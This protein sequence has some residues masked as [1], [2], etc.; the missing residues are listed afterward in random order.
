MVILIIIAMPSLSSS[1][2]CYVVKWIVI[3]EGYG[4]RNL[5]T[6]DLHFGARFSVDFL[7]RC[8]RF[9]ACYVCCL[10]APNRRTSRAVVRVG[11][12]LPD[13]SN[14]GTWF[15]QRVSLLRFILVGPWSAADRTSFLRQTIHF[16]GVNSFKKILFQFG[17]CCCL[18]CKVH[19]RVNV[20]VSCS[21][22]YLS[23]V[24]LCR[25][26][27]FHWSFSWKNRNLITF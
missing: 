21:V 18:G 10:R 2:A 4:S 8:V 16:E 27:L 13:F 15:P 24:V 25:F 9:P 7:L 17:K 20:K 14:R 1:S 11:V 6:T 3:L 26:K 23:L 12:V 19:F 5:R 22:G